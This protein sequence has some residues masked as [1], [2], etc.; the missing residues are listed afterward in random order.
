ML[1]IAVFHWSRLSVSRG[2]RT[3]GGRGAPSERD[4]LEELSLE[5]LLRLPSS[6][7]RTG[8][9]LSPRLPPRWSAHPGR[10][11][12]KRILGALPDSRRPAGWIGSTE[13]GH[14]L[15]ELLEGVP[16]H[17]RRPFSRPGRRAVFNHLYFNTGTFLRPF[18]WRTWIEWKWSTGPPLDLWRQRHRG[19]INVITRRATGEGASRRFGSRLGRWPQ[20]SPTPGRRGAKAIWSSRWQGASTTVRSTRRRLRV[21]VFRRFYY[22]DRRLL[23]RFRRQL[24]HRCQSHRSIESATT[25]A[26]AGGRW[27]SASRVSCSTRGYGMEYPGDRAQADRSGRGR[28]RAWLRRTARMGRTSCPRRRSGGARASRRDSFFVEAGGDDDEGQ[29]GSGGEVFRIVGRRTRAGPESGFEGRSEKP[30]G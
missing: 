8:P 18:P 11:S 5:D 2:I 24:G 25:C 20:K 1:A 13:G 22:G 16:K 17:D 14:L 3:Q 30:G 23:G 4:P 12:P 26:R 29:V 15:Q 6:R 28:T 21:R 7:R 27:R 10:P 9:S 19:V